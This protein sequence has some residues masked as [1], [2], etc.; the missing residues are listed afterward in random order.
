MTDAEQI[1]T[2]ARCELEKVLPCKGTQL[3]EDSLR[4]SHLLFTHKVE[5]LTENLANKE[6]EDHVQTIIL[7][8]VVCFVL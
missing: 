3:S 6:K 8:W 5:V 2:S 1:Q 4:K 7:C